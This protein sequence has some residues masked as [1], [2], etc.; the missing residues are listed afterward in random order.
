MSVT[1]LQIDSGSNSKIAVCSVH[2]KDGFPS[3]ENPIPTEFLSPKDNEQNLFGGVAPEKEVGPHIIWPDARFFT[4]MK[5]SIIPILKKWRLLTIK[6]VPIVLA[7]QK[8]H[9]LQIRLQ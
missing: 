2:F 1:V 6:T 3:S 9:S 4:E 8:C 5:A 7:I